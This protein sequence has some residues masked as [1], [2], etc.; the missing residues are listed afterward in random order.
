MAASRCTSGD[1]G[2]GSAEEDADRNSDAA[3]G[4]GQVQAVPHHHHLWSQ[5]CAATL[6]ATHLPTAIQKLLCSATLPPWLA[7]LVE[8]NAHSLVLSQVSAVHR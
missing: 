7:L 3:S 8:D 5:R 1:Q 2:A 6:A 4:A